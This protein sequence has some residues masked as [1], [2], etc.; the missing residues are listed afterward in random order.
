MGTASAMIA[1][2]WTIGPP[3]G[4]F[5]FV[6]GGFQLP[7]L[8]LGFFP[9]LSL[10]PL[11]S[12]WPKRAAVADKSAAA[13]TEKTGSSSP[14]GP[15]PSWTTLLCQMHADIWVVVLSAFLFM[16]KWGW[17][18]LPRYCCNLPRATAISLVD[19]GS[20]LHSLGRRRAGHEHPDGFAVPLALRW[21]L[22]RLCGVSRRHKMAAPS[23]L[24]DNL[25][26]WIGAWAR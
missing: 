20:I 23:R 13:E 26:W 4:G 7:F 24:S 25:P 8:V 3:T 1:L 19:R 5:L 12:L 18:K 10:G 11:L 16:S 15:P 22:P 6:L 14:A 2:G 21:G 9:I 17:C